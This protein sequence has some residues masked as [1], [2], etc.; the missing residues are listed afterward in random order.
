MANELELVA[1]TDG[2]LWSVRVNG[3]VFLVVRNRLADWSGYDVHAMT[4]GG[5]EYLGDTPDHQGA[6]ALI[7]AE[8]DG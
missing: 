5:V 3:S 4:D 7:Q 1:E 8:I 2:V 6:L